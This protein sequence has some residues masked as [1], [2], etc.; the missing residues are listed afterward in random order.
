MQKKYRARIDDIYNVMLFLDRVLQYG[1]SV[2]NGCSQTSTNASASRLIVFSMP[3]KGSYTEKAL[4][5]LVQKRKIK[6]I[7]QGKNMTLL[8]Q[9]VPM[10][11]AM[12]QDILHKNG[13]FMQ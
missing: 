2:W 12:S 13:L 3:V 6:R 11:Y 5:P 9:L 8:R 10:L 7:I 4:T 1:N